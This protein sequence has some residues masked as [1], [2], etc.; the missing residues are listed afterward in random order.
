MIRIID[1][2]AVC[3]VVGEPIRAQKFP[4]RMPEKI[5]QIGRKANPGEPDNVA[6]EEL[7]NL[8]HHK[9]RWAS[10]DD[11]RPFRPSIELSCNPV[12]F[13]SEKL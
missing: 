5:T 9:V 6:I 2:A 3:G 8:T 13:M 7:I 4:K 10:S 11:C 1:R 12:S